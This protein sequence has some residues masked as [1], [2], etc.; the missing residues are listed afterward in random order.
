ME[1]KMKERKIKNRKNGKGV[2]VDD[3]ME[4]R[5]KEKEGGGGE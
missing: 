1:G 4:E 5:R 3:R 2:K